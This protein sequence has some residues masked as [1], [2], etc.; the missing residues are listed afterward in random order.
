[1]VM[2]NVFVVADYQQTP[3]EINL[4][5]QMMARTANGVLF[6]SPAFVITSNH[7]PSLASFD[8]ILIT[9]Q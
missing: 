5:K 4:D 3:C 9:C 7:F 1:M 2:Q 6:I 8:F